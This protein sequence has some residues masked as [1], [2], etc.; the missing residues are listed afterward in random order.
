MQLH[1]FNP[2]SFI[3]GI[4]FIGAAAAHYVGD[5]WDLGLDGR[6]IWPTLLVV[7]GIAIVAGS[8]N[9]LGDRET[10]PQD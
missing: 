7:A 6:W 9:A 1:R 3:F 10:P 4:L 8:V 5:A 2:V